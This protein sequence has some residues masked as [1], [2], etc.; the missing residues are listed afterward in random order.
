MRDALGFLTVLP[1]RGGWPLKSSAIAAFPLAGLAIGLGW[2][3]AAWA[4]GHIGGPLLAAALVLA[5]DF[6]VTGGLHLDGLA[7]TA[8]GMAS[9]RPPE[10]VREV[11]KDPRIGAV[12]AAA[13]GTTLLL[14]FALLATVI[15]EPGGWWAIALAP[16]VGRLTLVWLLYRTK[17]GRASLAAGP[18]AATTRLAVSAAALWSVAIAAG[19]GYASGIGPLAALA[20]VAAGLL[21][22]DL[23]A[24]R[25]RR[26]LGPSGDTMGAAAVMAEIAALAA[27]ALCAKLF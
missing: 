14:R 12:G 20:A 6:A 17:P 11:M 8:D 26:R 23:A 4:G 24:R 13:L 27:L 15:P 1:V 2:A 3:A 21:T 7:D 18:A 25:W 16:V 22:A 5:L 9:R 19:L 10:Q